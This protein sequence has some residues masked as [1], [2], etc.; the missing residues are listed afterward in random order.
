M[1]TLAVLVLTM[2]A[3]ARAKPQ[4]RP[5]PQ[6]SYSGNTSPIPIIRYSNEISPD[7]SYAWSY[8]TGN[9]IAADESGALENPGQKDLEAMRAQG[10]FSYTAPDGSPISVRYVADRDGF[11]PEGAHLPT[12]PPIPP[13]IQRALDFIASQPQQP[14]NNGGGQFP[15]PQ[16]F[17]RPGAF[18]RR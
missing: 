5:Q 1:N 4:F 17:P 16:P 3:L 9:G 2:V 11:H 14:G 6:P 10:S 12:P 13:A 18:G 15:R 8:E 7:G